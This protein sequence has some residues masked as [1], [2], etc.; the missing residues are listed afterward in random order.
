M[1]RP[2]LLPGESRSVT[3][4]QRP[5]FSYSRL[6]C[7]VA[8]LGGARAPFSIQISPPLLL[9]VGCCTCSWLLHRTQ[10]CCGSALVASLVWLSP[11]HGK[12]CKR[13][14][15]PRQTTL[16]NLHKRHNRRGKRYKRHRSP[17]QTL[18]RGCRDASKG[19][20]G[21]GLP[22]RRWFGSRLASAARWTASL[23]PCTRASPT[24]QLRCATVP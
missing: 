9:A 20:F 5:S 1:R 22:R 17:R 12:R 24:T 8:S 6:E 14:K 3:P 2:G 4:E 10:E 13:H 21:V 23:P 15:S 7:Q 16:P 19:S 18:L 11:P